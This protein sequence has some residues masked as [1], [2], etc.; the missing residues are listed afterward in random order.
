MIASVPI[1]A[2][3]AFV[4][5]IRQPIFLIIVLGVGILEMLN[6]WSAAYSMGYSDTAEVSGD[7]KVMLD[8]GLSTI[9]V[10]G[11][12]LAAFTAT[13]VISKEI[14]AKTVL[15]V[16]SKPVPRVSVIIG[17]F[18][19]VSAAI[20]L[21]TVCMVIFLLLCVRHGVMSTV[22]DKL[23]QPVL[24]FTLSAVFLSLAIGAIC[25]FLY[26]W[27]FPQT[28]FLVLTPALIVA[29]IAVLL[30]SKT[31]EFQP[32]TKDFKP[33]VTL[34][35]AAMLFAVL[36]LT[37]VAVAASTRLGQVMTIAACASVFL[38]GLLTNH[39][40]GRHAFRNEPVARVASA[41]SAT[42]AEDAFTRPGDTYNLTLDTPPTRQIKPGDLIYYGDNPNG[43]RL[44]VGAA[45]PFEGDPT[46]RADATSP[47]ANPGII[48]VSVENSV[49][50]IR[51]AGST[52]L[53]VDRPPRVN[54]F[55][56]LK[57]TETNP[58]AVAAWAVVPNM[59]S[60][61]LLDAITQ[62][63][64]IPVQHVGL[65]ALYSLMQIGTMLAL[66]TLLF[67]RRDVG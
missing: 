60:F 29:Y 11:M 53:R 49:M 1:I 40:I 9:F 5:S 65:I 41:S 57:P 7:N 22:A 23:D 51:H 2:R 45:Q 6:V 38:F 13:A 56:F 36:V 64:K 4:E 14:D 66:A 16:V 67:Q 37:S 46:S 44:P 21:A 52:P 15:T 12:L 30:I 58:V 34:A 3:N 42:P 55:I 10:A 47:R 8:I 54:D 18:L 59:H 62:N 27:S 26:G 48:L 63:H 17:K 61:W 20:T 19:G 24:V 43:F 28:S 25:N 31:W 32:P 35:C 39:L 50:T 33:Q